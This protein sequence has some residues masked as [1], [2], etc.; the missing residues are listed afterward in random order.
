M[1]KKERGENGKERDKDTKKT[2]E[3]NT[4]VSPPT[5]T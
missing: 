3:F 5:A 4:F 2:K 1:N